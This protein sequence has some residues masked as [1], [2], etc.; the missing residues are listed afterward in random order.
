MT[1]PS[2]P[3]SQHINIIVATTSDGAIGRGGDL[4]YH[5][6]DD[7]RNFRR[8]T[9]GH[10]VIMGRRTFESLPKGALPQRRNIV[11]SRNPEFNAPGIEVFPS[12]SAAVDSVLTAPAVGDIDNEIFI[13][14]GAQVYQ[15]AIAL[16]GRLY[17][18][19]IEAV[20]DD[21]DTF[22]PAIDP[23]EWALESAGQWTLDPKADVRYRFTC[24]SRK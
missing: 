8:L 1:Q 13:I 24:L 5:I 12:L 10:T 6:S 4:L 22:F 18:T 21:A 3:H 9:T 19:E 20:A 14:G 11:V 2:A 16:A 23:A 7:L 15:Q 17:V